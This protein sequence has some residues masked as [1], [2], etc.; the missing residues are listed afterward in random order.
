ME[1]NISGKMDA[2]FK[3]LEMSVATPTPREIDVIQVK[4]GWEEEGSVFPL[5]DYSTLLVDQVMMSKPQLMALND[6]RKALALEP[7]E[8]FKYLTL[9]LK[10]RV[11]EVNGG[12]TRRHVVKQLLIPSFFQTLLALVGKVRIA[13][14]GLEMVPVWTDD[15]KKGTPTSDKPKIEDED[16]DFM[17]NVSKKLSYH[18]DCLNLEKAAMPLEVTGD[19]A[20]MLTALI[21]GFVCS[22]QSVDNGFKCYASSFLRMRLVKEASFKVLYRVQYNDADELARILLTKKEA[23]A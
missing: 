20:L 11:T 22:M 21:D 10:V 15:A 1:T 17:L 18:T 9:L 4:V 19:H 7:G 23:F 14:L 13:Q 16:W 6:S 8:V 5:L 3:N 2:K 12:G